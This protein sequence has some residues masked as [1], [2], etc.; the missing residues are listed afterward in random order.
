MLK[1]KASVRAI[2]TAAAGRFDAGLVEL[3]ERDAVQTPPE[4]L[5]A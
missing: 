3:D 2:V 1:A 5:P 4:R